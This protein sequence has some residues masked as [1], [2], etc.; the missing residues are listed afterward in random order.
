MS[1]AWQKRMDVPHCWSAGRAWSSSL[2]S[3][4]RL[5]LR[6][7]SRGDMLAD[8]FLLSRYVWM[9]AGVASAKDPEALFQIQRKT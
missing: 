7:S 8:R 1:L 2:A 6:T 3:R 4:V 9:W 5:G